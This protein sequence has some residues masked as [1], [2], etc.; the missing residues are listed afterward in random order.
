MRRSRCSSCTKTYAA[1]D[2]PLGRWRTWLHLPPAPLAAP[3]DLDPLYPRFLPQSLDDDVLRDVT[4]SWR[5]A[6][7]RALEYRWFVE[8]WP[9]YTRRAP[10]DVA[11]VV[12]RLL[13]SAKPEM[14]QLAHELRQ[15]QRVQR[16]RARDRHAEWLVRFQV[17][18]ESTVQL[19]AAVGKSR[20]AVQDAVERLAERAGTTPLR[21]FDRS[22]VPYRWRR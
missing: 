8:D 13:A 14:E 4:P 16:L 19:G 10:R 18:G 9:E 22:G 5:R 15:R 11:R 20:Q 21:E 17:G 7:E 12:R 6:I 1:W 2:E 3:H